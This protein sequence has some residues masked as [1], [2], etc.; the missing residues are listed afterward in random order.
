MIVIPVVMAAAV[1]AAVAPA[2]VGPVAVMIIVVAIAV[3]PAIGVI[4]I[5]LAVVTAVG[6]IIVIVVIA[7]VRVVTGAGAAEAICLGG[8][9]DGAACALRGA[10]PQRQRHEGAEEQKPD[11]SGARGH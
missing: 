9:L 7:A 4:V 8:G 6:V 5:V 11:G 3:M 2:A 10:A 1:A